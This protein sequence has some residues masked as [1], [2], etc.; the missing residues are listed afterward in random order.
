MSTPPYDDVDLDFTDPVDP[1]E[2]I[3][4]KRSSGGRPDVSLPGIDDP[5][6][7][8]RA[9]LRA[10]ESSSQ[11]TEPVG[12]G[13][14]GK[15][16]KKP[17][18]DS[19][20]SGLGNTKT[21]PE[22]RE[23]KR[24]RTKPRRRIRHRRS[25]FTWN[26]YTEDEWTQLTQT[27]RAKAK[28]WIVGK[29]VGDSG[30]PHLQ[31]YVEWNKQ[32]DFTVLKKINAAIHWEPAKGTREQNVKY[33][34]KDGDYECF[35]LPLSRTRRLLKKYDGVTWY[36]WQAKIIELVDSKRTERDIVWVRDSVG[37]KGKSYLAKFLV[38]KYD[39]IISQG[40][41]ADVFNQVKQWLEEHPEADPSLCVLD[42][43]RSS[44]GFLNYGLL[45]Q[46]KNG[47]LYSGKYEGGKCLFDPPHVVVFA[48]MLPKDG[49]FS[50]DRITLIDL[51][52]E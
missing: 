34:S 38:L 31:G 21:S 49:E 5:R 23:R 15:K 45:E 1:A 8:K 16:R 7:S 37:N 3:D 39:A 32:T 36:E 46:L 22:N 11:D 30:T 25:V 40:K 13:P 14:D 10:L 9:L 51:D 24:L 28:S 26:N 35:G 4:K 50:D 48:N 41:S 2:F 18:V 6:P 42:V 33:C 52:D 20:D 12:S 27:L 17:D 43:P 47:C 29:E 19:V 44:F